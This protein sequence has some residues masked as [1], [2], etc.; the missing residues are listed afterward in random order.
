METY[1]EFKKRKQDAI[2]EFTNKNMVFA[3]GKEQLKEKLTELG[4]TEEEFQDQ[5]CGYCGGAMRKDKVKE[6]CQLCIKWDKELKSKMIE[7]E[8]FAI[9]AFEA[10]FSNY[11][12][13]IGDYNDALNALSI[14][15]QDIDEDG[16]LHKAYKK[17]LRKYKDWCCEHI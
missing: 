3:F 16:P 8:E 2:T 9:E 6:W 15:V 14:E 4:L 12:C 11:E 13:F 5:Y 7:N 1:Q 17:A 10:E